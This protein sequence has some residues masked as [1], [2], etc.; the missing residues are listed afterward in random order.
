MGTKEMNQLLTQSIAAFKTYRKYSGKQKA[1][2]L[3]AIAAELESL[4]DS[5]IQTAGEESH[6][7]AARLIGER[8]RTTGQLRLFA[9]YIEEGSW[10]DATLDT[11]IPDRKKNADAPGNGGGFRRKQF[12]V[13]IFNRRRGYGLRFSLRLYGGGQSASRTYQNFPISGRCH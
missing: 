4:G 7:P 1:E 9:Q 6:L 12:P 10:V 2:F 11:A 8:G 13:G 3:R 5:L